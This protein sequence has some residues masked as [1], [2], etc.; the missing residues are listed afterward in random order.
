[1]NQPYKIVSD[2]RTLRALAR[3]G[4]ISEPAESLRPKGKRWGTGYCY[5]KQGEKNHFTRKGRFYWVAYRD[6]CFLPFVFTS[7]GEVGA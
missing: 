6:G 1:M 5:V 3:V 2:G 4:Y 7:N